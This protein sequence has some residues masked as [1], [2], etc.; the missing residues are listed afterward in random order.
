MISSDLLGIKLSQV[1]AAEGNFF[2][3]FHV[4]AHVEETGQ[5]FARQ[6]CRRLTESD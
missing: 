5:T 6:P 4:S 1:N 3:Q 2:L